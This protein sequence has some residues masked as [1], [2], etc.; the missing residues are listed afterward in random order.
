[1]IVIG[2]GANLPH[3]EYGP[4]RRTCGAAMAMLEQRGIQIANRSTWYRTAPVLSDP[5]GA[6]GEQPWYVNGAASVIS[7]VPPSDLL[8]V[9][10][11]IEIV[12]GRVRS[13]ANAP[14]TLDLDM[15]TYND[16]II[17]ENGLTVPH[18]RMHERAFVLYPLRDLA[19]VWHHPFGKR[20]VDEMINALPEDQ[21]FQVMEDADGQFGTEWQE[22]SG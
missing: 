16:E 5:Q 6:Q 2:V 3:P 21:S 17:D 13:I 22:K 9:L 14:R 11:D 10:L 12:F 8:Q 18:P 15:V 7:D 19:P 1:M 4:P 20:T